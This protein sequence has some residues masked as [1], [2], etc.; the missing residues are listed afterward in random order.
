[1]FFS[2]FLGDN[3][4]FLA[5]QVLKSK[6]FKFYLSQAPNNGSCHAIELFEHIKIFLQ[7]KE[8]V[9]AFAFQAQK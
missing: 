2:T 4:C 7:E 3:D 8:C 5:V 9:L 1:M 6:Y